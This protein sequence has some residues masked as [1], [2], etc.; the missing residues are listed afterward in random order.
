MCFANGGT[1][2]GALR[3]RAKWLFSVVSRGGGMEGKKV[4][5][6]IFK[7]SCGVHLNRKETDE[8]DLRNLRDRMFVLG[9]WNL[10][11]IEMIAISSM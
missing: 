11:I 9:F 6:K 2:T 7:R 5:E 3:E 4:E 1:Y 8:N 10:W